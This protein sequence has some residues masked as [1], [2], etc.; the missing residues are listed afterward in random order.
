MTSAIHQQI[1]GNAI[2]YQGI[3]LSVTSAPYVESRLA[4]AWETAQCAMQGNEK[5]IV[6]RFEIRIPHFYMQGFIFDGNKLVVDTIQ[7]IKNMIRKANGQQCNAASKSYL[8]ACQWRSKSVP[9]GR[10]KSVPVGTRW[11]DVVL[12]EVRS[13]AARQQA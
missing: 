9:L 8:S 1:R 12:A 2:E 6:C 13:G 7:Y 11:F 3:Q 10:S 4:D 5:I